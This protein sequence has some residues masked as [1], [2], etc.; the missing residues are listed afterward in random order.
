MKLEVGELSVNHHWTL[1]TLQNTYNNPVVIANTLSKNGGSQATARIRNVTANSFE[2]RVQEWLYLD[3][4]HYYENLSYMVVESGNYVLDNGL[5]I[6][7]G[8]ISTNKASV[9]RPYENVIFTEPFSVWCPAATT[10]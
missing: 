9:R 1:V 10:K 7:A 5:H 6:E 2:I 3:G 8:L 4:K